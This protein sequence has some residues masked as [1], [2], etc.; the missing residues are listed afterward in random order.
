MKP[1]NIYVL[2]RVADDGLLKKLERQMSGRQYFL[3]VKRW[4]MICLREVAEELNRRIGQPER[5][6]FFYSFQ[7]PKLGKEF[8]LLRISEDTVLNLELK[9]GFVSDDKIKRQL[10]QNR[11]YLAPLGKNIRSYTYISQSHRLVR[12]T[13][14][15]R[16]VEE[17]W[18]VLCRDILQQEN[19]YSGDMELLFREEKYLIS[20]LTDPE[21][22]L[23][24]EYFLT[25]QQNDI[26]N[27]ILH[28]IREKKALAQ[29]TAGIEKEALTQSTAGKETLAQG[30]AGIERETE[31]GKTLLQGFTGLPGTGKTLL[32]YDIAMEL[33]EHE[34]VCVLHYGSYPTQL[35]MLDFRLKRIDFYPCEKGNE[36]PDLSGYRAILVDEGHHMYPEDFIALQTYAKERNVPIVLSY[37]REDM[38]CRQERMQ[39]MG[40]FLEKQ[41]GFVRYRLTNRIRMNSEL[42]SFIHNLLQTKGAYRRNSYPSVEVAYADSEEEKEQLIR[43][44]QQK[45]YIYVYQGEP[46]ANVDR[47]KSM[48]AGLATCREF[49]KV[50]MVLDERFYYDEAGYLRTGM[51]NNSQTPEKGLVRD[52]F[53]GLNRAT[54]AIGLVVKKNEDVLKTILQILQYRKEKWG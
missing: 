25:S 16:L 42:S 10:R 14:G 24:R 4:E 35:D 8:D 38:I 39:D 18:E 44:F 47:E 27:S 20:P 50:L 12:L 11:Y 28:R 5:L 36:M 53:H 7:V 52:L 45:D 22:F 26:K 17:D 34:K 6:T 33:S 43:I 2:S 13:N 29:G 9:S 49:Q 31:Q 41:P 3:N 32:L 51:M 15:N 21:R 37:D 23:R 48:E 54:L 30:T 1:I 46:G 19:C 40:A